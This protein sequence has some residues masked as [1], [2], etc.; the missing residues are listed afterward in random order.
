MMVSSCPFSSDVS[1]A[2]E[3]GWSGF[4]GQVSHTDG[5]SLAQPAALRTEVPVGWKGACSWYLGR[6]PLWL[7]S[8]V[9]EV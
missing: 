8:L 1:E 6:V 3:V 5:T 7:A 2:K 9:P 4:N